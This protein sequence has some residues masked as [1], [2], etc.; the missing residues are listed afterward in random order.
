MWNNQRQ[1]HHHVRFPVQMY[2][3]GPLDATA[4]AG[5]ERRRRVRASL[6]YPAGPIP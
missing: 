3:H 1:H 4:A 6:G 2:A 5:P